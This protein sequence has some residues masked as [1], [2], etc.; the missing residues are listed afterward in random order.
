MDAFFSICTGFYECWTKNERFRIVVNPFIVNHDP[1]PV[2]M[3]ISCAYKLDY[4]E[5]RHHTYVFDPMTIIFEFGSGSFNI[6]PAFLRN[7]QQC[8]YMI[9]RGVLM[10]YV[11]DIKRIIIYMEKTPT[12]IFINP[13]IL[14]HPREMLVVC[15]L[16]GVSIEAL[17]NRIPARASI[18]SN[19]DKIIEELSEQEEQ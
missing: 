7:A 6:D 5:R 13:H 14:Y 19:L 3:P 4:R 15:D 2:Y 10:G 8:N 1:L 9:P 16:N 11:D 12:S 17:P 18:I